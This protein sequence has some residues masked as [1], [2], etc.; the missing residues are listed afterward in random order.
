MR[1]DY[2]LIAAWKLRDL[3]RKHSFD[4]I[5]AH[6]PT[7]HAISLIAA[8]LSGIPGLVVTRRVIFK[9]KRN[10]FS[11]WKYLSHRINR[12]VAASNAIGRILQRYGVPPARV[13]VIPDAVDLERFNPKY[14]REEARKQ[15][16]IGISEKV[17]GT[18]GN[19][20]WVKGAHQHV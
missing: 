1:Q 20:G 14:D 3:I 9:I 19:I 2:D 15:L 6:H 4:L 17:I 13:A 11:R 10:P 8:R 18:G 7:A 12:F 16:G 5:H